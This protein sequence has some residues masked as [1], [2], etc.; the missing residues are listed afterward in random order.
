MTARELNLTRA[1]TPGDR[2]ADFLGLAYRETDGMDAAVLRAIRLAAIYRVHC[3]CRHGQLRRGAAA[4][5]ALQQACREVVKGHR[6]AC[7]V[8][9]AVQSCWWRE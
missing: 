3:L 4:A 7:R 8:Y 6:A 1:A 5:E 9:D 2:L